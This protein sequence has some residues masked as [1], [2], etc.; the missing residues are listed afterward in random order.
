MWRL[1]RQR[2]S[3]PT[4][5]VECDDHWMPRGTGREVLTEACAFVT[6]TITVF[7]RS[8][9]EQNVVPP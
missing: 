6:I 8:L 1:H 3:V 2:R 9:W 5:A 7:F 4:I